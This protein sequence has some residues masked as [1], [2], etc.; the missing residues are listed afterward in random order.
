VAWTRPAACI[1]PLLAGRGQGGGVGGGGHRRRLFA[2]EGERE[3]RGREDTGE[4]EGGRERG[5]EQM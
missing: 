4:R 5:Q 3:Q 2:T 1:L